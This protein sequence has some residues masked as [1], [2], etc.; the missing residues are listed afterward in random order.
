M[1]TESFPGVKRP[2]RG[3]DHPPLL[4]FRGQESRAI[5]LLPSKTLG[6]LR[7]ARRTTLLILPT[8]LQKFPEYYGRC[9]EFFTAFHNFYVLIQRF[10]AE[11]LTSFTA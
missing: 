10:L 5:S 1:G 11:T 9:W 7:G 8:A 3:T 6:L 4:V 2:R